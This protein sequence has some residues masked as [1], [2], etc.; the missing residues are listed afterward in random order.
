MNKLLTG[1]IEAYRKRLN[2]L[3][4]R[5]GT[6]HQEVLRC[7]QRLDMLIYYSYKRGYYGNI[8]N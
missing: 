6:Q 5:Y 4:E 2:R 3:I 1:K 7:S 8:K